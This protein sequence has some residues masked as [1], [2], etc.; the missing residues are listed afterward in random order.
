VRTRRTAMRGGELSALVVAIR[1][2]RLRGRSTA[3]PQRGR[4]GKA[5]HLIHR[6]VTSERGNGPALLPVPRRPGG[7]RDRCVAC[8]RRRAGRSRRS[9]P[10]TGKPSAWGRAAAGLR[11]G[12]TVNARR[13]WVNTDAPTESET[14]LPIARLFTGLCAWD[15]RGAGWW[16]QQE[17]RR[18]SRR[19][20]FSA[21]LLTFGRRACRSAF[22]PP[23]VSETAAC[24]VLSC[25]QAPNPSDCAR[26]GLAPLA[27]VRAGVVRRGGA[28][29]ASSGSAA[30]ASGRKRNGKPN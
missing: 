28:P 30:R 20:S 5:G 8:Q 17:G 2:E 27:V 14:I 15:G 4:R 19:R 21:S 24:L 29:E 1:C 6:V 23:T 10:R 9:T 3:Y 7:I 22:D 12:G 26:S 18:W 25:P 11:G 16:Q 13:S